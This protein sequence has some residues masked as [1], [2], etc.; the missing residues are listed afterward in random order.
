MFAKLLLP[1]FGGSTSVWTACMLFYQLFLLFGYGYAHLVNKL[2]QVKHQYAI[3]AAILVASIALMPIS[4][5]ETN[6][7][8]SKEPALSIVLILTLS[9][10]LPYAA[11]SATSPLLQ[12]WLSKTHSA[13]TTYRLYA[14]SNIGSFIALFSYPFLLEFSTTL[15]TQKTIWS[16]LFFGFAILLLSMM[17]LAYSEN[18]DAKRSIKEAPLPSFRLKTL[19]FL[20][21]ASGV[22]L[23][24]AT[25][26]NMTINIPPVPFL[27]VLPL[28]LYLLTFII[29]FGKESSSSSLYWRIALLF[30]GLIGVLLFFISSQFNLVTQV[31]LYLLVFFVACLVCHKELAKLKPHTN[32]LTQ[33]YLILAF[34]GAAGS[35]FASLISVN[36]FDHYYEYIVGLWA[37]IFLTLTIDLYIPQSSNLRLNKVING[38][39][40]ASLLLSILLFSQLHGL[41]N[42]FNVYQTRNFYGI[43][44][45]KDLNNTSPPQRRLIDGYTSHGSQELNQANPLPQSYYRLQTGIGQ[46]LSDTNQ[47]NNMQV[48]IIGLGVGALAYYGQEQQTYT[49]YE[50]NPDVEYVA[51]HYFD[52]IK[53]SSASVQVKL[54]DARITLQKELNQNNS[55]PYQVLIIDAF[56][57]DAIPMHLLTYEAFEVYANSITDNGVLAFHVSNSYLNLV[58]VI[59]SHADSLDYQMVLT[60]TINHEATKHKAQWLFVSKNQYFVKQ[61]QWNSYFLQTL[62]IDDKRVTWTDDYSSLLSVLKQPS[63]D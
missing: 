62:A 30:C 46:L 52:Y 28:A 38:T 23:L 15:E 57:S 7:L 12:A 56:S 18:S 25:T 44:Q 59:A 9:I 58:P 40:V 48:G 11:L 36:I 5:A 60:E 47:F 24:V 22:I 35:A 61:K 27:W 41:F 51:N 33:Y 63:E 8:T 54:G 21:S 6:A 49:F 16:T 39:N 32:Y 29:A 17:W 31:V 50:I 43:L 26:N 14:V 19:W 2:N 45:V 20:L 1:R 34:G 3:H 4:L 55:T 53:S 37:I 13:E 10:G 42:Q